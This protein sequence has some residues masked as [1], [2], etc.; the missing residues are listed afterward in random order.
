[1][2]AASLT[3]KVPAPVPET[4]WEKEAA[5]R[6][7]RQLIGVQ[8][9]ERH[10]EKVCAALRNFVVGK[11]NLAEARLLISEFE[12]GLPLSPSGRKNFDRAVRETCLDAARFLSAML[13]IPSSTVPRGQLLSNAHSDVSRFSDHLGQAKDIQLGLRKV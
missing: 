9:A 5:S 13:T 4:S 6:M 3:T 7:L 8:G 12:S 1:M 10:T 11:G 2:T